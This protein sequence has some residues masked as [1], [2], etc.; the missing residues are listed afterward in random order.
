MRVPYI[1]PSTINQPQRKQ[2]PPDLSSRLKRSGGTSFSVHPNNH[3]KGR[4]QPYPLSSR[5]DLGIS[6]YAAP[7]TN[8][9]AAFFKES[10][11]KL[12]TPR[13][14]TG[15][16]GVAERSAVHFTPIKPRG[17]QPPS[18]LSSRPKRSGETCGSVNETN[19]EGRARLLPCR[20]ASQLLRA[21]APEVRL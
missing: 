9:C 20:T 2:P 10:R 14:F 13:R 12:T 21:L 3:R 15:K 17:K 7:N 19:F 5:A 16:P 8:T 1:P 4:N 6:Y 18:D 11:M